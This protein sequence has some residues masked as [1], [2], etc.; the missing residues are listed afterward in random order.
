MDDVMIGGIA[1][2]RPPCRRLLSCDGEGE[3]GRRRA[4]RV[5][6]K[7]AD[8]DLR[9][10]DHEPSSESAATNHQRRAS[11]MFD[12]SAQSLTGTAIEA[13]P[14]ARLHHVFMC[15]LRYAVALAMTIM[16]IHSVLVP[17]VP[18]GSAACDRACLRIRAQTSS[19]RARRRPRLQPAE[20]DVIRLDGVPDEP[21]WER[22]QPATGFLQRRSRQRRAGDRTHRSAAV[23]D[24]DRLIL[25]VI[26]HDSEPGRVLGNQMQRDRSFDADDRFMWTLDT[27]LDGRTGYF[28]EINPSGAMGDGLIDPASIPG[29]AT[30][31]ASGS[32]GRGT[33]SGWRA[34]AA[35]RPAGRAEI[36]I[37]FRTVN[38][39]PNGRPGAST[40][41]AP[42]AARTRRAS[43][44]AM[45]GIRG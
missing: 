6:V 27:F 29:R 44:P 38:F 8:D 24:A 17:G 18:C 45:R 5:L 9:A 15:T 16:A 41:S 25:G 33:A 12:Q 43:G 7:R 21:A 19:R 42:S 3:A 37:P 26:C 2:Y 14:D 13:G 30:T 40:S 22:A 28:F 23:Y 4:D 32:T 35:P 11:M 20:A 34:C 31:S 36:E 10:C 39:D 1:S